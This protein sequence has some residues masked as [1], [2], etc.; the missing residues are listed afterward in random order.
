MDIKDFSMK[1]NKLADRT[2]ELERGTF[3]IMKKK[4]LNFIQDEL[5][6]CL[7]RLS[8][9]SNSDSFDQIDLRNFFE[10]LSEI[11]TT[12]SIIKEEI[13]RI[14]KKNEKSFLRRILK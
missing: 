4:N 14:N 1:L 5:D 8:I 3:A 10:P 2:K 9:Y 7:S 11:K 13:E 6:A 12:L